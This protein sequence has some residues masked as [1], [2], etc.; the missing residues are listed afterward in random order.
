MKMGEE[1]VLKDRGYKIQRRHKRKLHENNPHEVT[2]GEEG[3]IKDRG[4]DILLPAQKT[5][6]QTLRRAPFPLSVICVPF[7]ASHTSGDP[8][9]P[10]RISPLPPV[11]MA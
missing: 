6:T 2:M 1:G 7:P 10:V 9:S 8:T 3:V 11:P 4:Y 5:K